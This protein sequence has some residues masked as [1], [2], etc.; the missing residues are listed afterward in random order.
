MN[1]RL[2]A[3]DGT[4]HHT[5]YFHFMTYVVKTCFSSSWFSHVGL[6]LDRLRIRWAEIHL[7]RFPLLDITIATHSHIFI[8]WCCRAAPQYAP[9]PPQSDLLLFEHCH[10][11]IIA[12]TG[13]HKTI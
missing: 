2:G 3:H 12:Y 13:G 7:I 5:A 1:I 10:A 9:S 6:V 8:I 4:L 11:L